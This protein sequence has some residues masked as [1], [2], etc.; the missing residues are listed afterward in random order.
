[1]YL[2]YEAPNLFPGSIIVFDSAELGLPEQSIL[3]YDARHV[4]L[5]TLKAVEKIKTGGYIMVGLRQEAI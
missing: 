3:P 4:W 2:L 1:M 5:R